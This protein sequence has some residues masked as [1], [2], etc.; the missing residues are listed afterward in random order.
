MLS[1][2]VADAYYLTGGSSAFETAYFIKKVDRFF[3]S[4]NV[5]HYDQGKKSRKEFH[6]PYRSEKEFR[7][8]VSH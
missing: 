3:D 8:D 6:Q 4:L 7:F 1:D 5:R 2:S